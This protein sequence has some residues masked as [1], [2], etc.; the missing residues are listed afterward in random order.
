VS[1]GSA[2]PVTGDKGSSG[3]K[4][5][6]TSSAAAARPAAAAAGPSTTTLRRQ[7]MQAPEEEDESDREEDLTRSDDD[8]EYEEPDVVEHPSVRVSAAAAA[9]AARPSRK[10]PFPHVDE[11]DD[12]RSDHEDK[13]SS[14]IT[15]YVDREKFGIKKESIALQ[16][17]AE[18]RKNTYSSVFPALSALDGQALNNN[19]EDVEILGEAGRL[20]EHVRRVLY[21]ENAPADIIQELSLAMKFVFTAN[22]RL[23]ARALYP[24][25]V[26]GQYIPTT[27]EQ[28]Y[29]STT[30]RDKLN[31]YTEQEESR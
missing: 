19:K 17:T 26:T 27:Q 30:D 12:D 18:T 31:D 21:E 10:R 2:G 25:K 3:R 22:R 9:A 28:G 14:N 16:A 11:D 4:A 15:A 24:A 6:A 13:Y 1:T 8:S 7:A 20:M 5:T 23:V 29:L